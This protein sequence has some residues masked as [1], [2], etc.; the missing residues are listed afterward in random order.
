MFSITQD[1]KGFIWFTSVLKGLQRYDGKKLTGYTHNNDNP[2]SLVNNLAVAVSVDSSGFIWVGTLGFGVD[3]L[4]PETKKFTHF[5]HDPKDP[6]SLGSDTVFAIITD[7]S[8]I[9]WVGTS[10]S[11][12]KF[13]PATGN[14]THYLID[15]LLK[16]VPASSEEI[17]IVNSIF[18]DSNGFLWVG[19]GDPFTGKPDGP[20]GLSRFDKSSGKFVHYKHDAGN[21]NSLSDNNVFA[22]LKTVKN[23]LGRYQRKWVT[24]TGSGYRKVYPVWL[25]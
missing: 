9:T 25:L 5:R 19:W 2:N 18:E 17:P 24:V 11:L 22:F 15:E 7:R 8:G 20:G 6:S 10:R 12:E 16:Y 23:T 14:F 21:P 1:Q 13:N 3:R 4:D